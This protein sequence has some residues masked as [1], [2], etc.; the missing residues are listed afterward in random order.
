[1]K[2][3]N[4]KTAASSSSSALQLQ[5]D[6]SSS[7]CACAASDSPSSSSSGKEHTNIDSTDTRHEHES[8]S[9]KGVGILGEDK[10]AV[11]DDN[12]DDVKDK[13]LVATNTVGVTNDT[14]TTTATTVT[15]GSDNGDDNDK[16]NKNNNNNNNDVND[17][18]NNNKKKKKKN[19]KQGQTL[20]PFRRDPF[21][22][23]IQSRLGM[24]FTIFIIALLCDIF[25]AKPILHQK[26]MTEIQLIHEI[27]QK[28]TGMNFE[29]TLRFINASIPIGTAPDPKLRPGYTLS[30]EGATAKYPVVL[31]PG[32]ITSG[33][34][35]WQ[36]ED[37]A[38]RHFR[39]RLWGSLPIFVQS[40]FT[41]MKCWSRHLALDPL[42]GGDPKNIR[43]RSAQGFEAADYFMST[44][45]VWD[46]IIENLSDVGYDSSNMI[47]MSYDW[48][49]SFATLERRDG[50]LTKLKANIEA[51][52]KT[53]GTKV[54]IASHSMGSQ[55]VLYFFKWVTTDEQDGGGGGGLDWVEKHCAKFVNIAG[56]LLGVPKAVPALLSGEMKDTAALLGPMGS[57]VERVFGKKDRKEL[58]TTWGSLW[59]MLPKGGD[60]IWGPHDIITAQ[61]DPPL[62]ESSE[63]SER[64]CHNVFSIKDGDADEFCQEK[65]HHA[66]GADARSNDGSRSHK[67]GVDDT[68][69]NS[70]NFQ[71]CKKSSFITFTQETDSL[72]PDDNVSNDAISSNDTNNANLQGN[73]TSKAMLDREWSITDS[74]DFLRKSGGGY[75]NDL[76]ASKSISPR[77]DS[78]TWNNPLVTPLP[79]AP[80]MK[81]Y[82]FYGVGIETE[83][84][85]FY[86]KL[87]RLET[88]VESFPYFL[89]GTMNDPEN[90]IHFGS[91]SSDGD[92]SVPLISLGYL[93][94][95]KWKTSKQLNPSDIHVITR[96]YKHREEFQVNDPMR[97]GPYS[98]DHVDILGNVDAMADLIKVV[99]DHNVDE[100]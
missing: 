77:P 84:A 27:M 25:L 42:T 65:V 39:Q 22:E 98:S 73:T 37:C 100:I 91:K 30:Q 61:Y 80:S 13:K 75:G 40:F 23:F 8:I 95:N 31:I 11:L 38:K 46:K 4:K 53:T 56:P 68:D 62:T 72:G 71:A 36:G 78:D 79:N 6:N 64:L 96:E 7:S 55:I 35:L 87:A 51:M 49:L 2:K 5:K 86:R 74:I 59:E 1:M 14:A 67:V 69:T 18:K 54:V 76:H 28:T 44:Y 45:W 81:I 93:C 88:N 92:V 47:M 19:T 17:N 99:T 85:Y 90:H 3:K 10:S 82:C 15:S 89:D 83:R 24:A 70:M 97:G 58:W 20:N 48:R 34:E 60:T 57:M 52:V 66:H 94:A 16:N 32:F 50:Y 9:S 63:L 21:S 26:G 41:D 43:L 12:D 29:N 33:L